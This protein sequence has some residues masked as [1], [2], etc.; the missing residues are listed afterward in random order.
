MS[1]LQS[2]TISAGVTEVFNFE[3]AAPDPDTAITVAMTDWQESG[4]ANWTPCGPAET[5]RY[6]VEQVHN[7]PNANIKTYLVSYLVTDRLKA[8]IQATSADEALRI[9]NALRD[10]GGTYEVSFDVANSE[11]T[12]MDVQEVVS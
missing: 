4:S 6:Q 8:H 12:E 3:V 10:N 2:Y 11:S 5:P 9:A 7:I 1:K